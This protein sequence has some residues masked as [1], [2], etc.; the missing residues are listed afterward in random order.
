MH[1]EAALVLV[2]F[3]L[4]I[5]QLASGLRGPGGC[6]SLVRALGPDARSLRPYLQRHLAVPGVAMRED[7]FEC[8]LDELPRW[9]A[10]QL[11]ADLGRIAQLA[12]RATPADGPAQAQMLRL[13]WSAPAQRL[14]GDVARRARD[15]GRALL[16]RATLPEPVVRRYEALF[17]DGRRS[18]EA[19]DVARLLAEHAF[20]C[21]HAPPGDSKLDRLPATSARHA[22]VILSHFARSRSCAGST[23]MPLPDEASAGQLVWQAASLFDHGY[24]KSLGLQE[25]EA[26]DYSR[27]RTLEKERAYNDML[28]FVRESM[29]N[30][31]LSS[32]SLELMLKIGIDVA[33]NCQ[34]PGST[35]SL[36]RGIITELQRR[37]GI[38]P[39]NN[40]VF[41]HLLTSFQRQKN[42][43]KVSI[44]DLINAHDYLVPQ[45]LEDFQKSVLFESPSVRAYLVTELSIYAK[46]AHQIP[47][48]RRVAL[49]GVATALLTI[50]WPPG[51]VLDLLIDSASLLQFGSISRQM[52]RKMIPA[53]LRIHTRPYYEWLSP[54]RKSYLYLTLLRLIEQLDKMDDSILVAIE[55]VVASPCEKLNL[56]SVLFRMLET[57][58]VSSKAFSYIECLI[59]YLLKVPRWFK[60]DWSVIIIPTAP[61][62]PC[63]P[64]TWHSTTG[65]TELSVETTP[66]ITFTETPSSGIEETSTPGKE[67]TTR[68]T[69]AYSTT[70]P[71]ESATTEIETTTE[72]SPGVSTTPS[73]AETTSK[74]TTV[75]PSS[76]ISTYET[77]GTSTTEEEFTT[78]IATSTST[79]YIETTGSTTVTP[80]STETSTTA[81]NTVPTTEMSA[82]TM[83]STSE[84]LTGTPFSETTS[85]IT[86]SE[87]TVTTTTEQTM[88]QT[89]STET[90]RLTT[91]T[92][93]PE[94][95]GSIETTA[96]TEFS[97]LTTTSTE[98]TSTTTELSS[99]IPTMTPSI[100]TTTSGST[101]STSTPAASEWTETTTSTAFTTTE[102]PSASQS[103]LTTFTE[104]TVTTSYEATTSTESSSTTFETPTSTPSLETT[105]STETTL[106][107]TETPAETPSTWATSTAIT[108]E[109][110]TATPSEGTTPEESSTTSTA[111]ETPTGSYSTVMTTSTGSTNAW[112][113]NETPSRSYSTRTTT[114]N[115]TP[116]ETFST[117]TTTSMSTETPSQTYSTATTTS[118]STEIPSESYSTVTT[119]S[120]T[121]TP[122]E[123]YSTMTTTT[124]TS[125]ETPSES[126]STVTTTSTS[127]TTPS[128]IYSTV[129]TTSSRESPSESYS[130]L[131]KTSTSTETPSE[132]YSTVT[133]T[134]RLTETPSESYSTVTTTSTS[135]ETPSESYSTVTT[136]STST[137]TPSESYSTVTTTSTSTE[138][139]SESYSTVTT[140]STSAET[141]S[142]SYPTETTTST[143]STTV[144]IETTSLTASTYGTTTETPAG[145]SSTETTTTSTVVKTSTEIP[146]ETPSVETTTSAESTTTSTSTQTPTG[147]YSLETTTTTG[148]E[149]FTPATETS[150]SVTHPQQTTAPPRPDNR[151]NDTT[152]PT[153]FRSTIVT[154]DNIL[155]MGTTVVTLPTPTPALNVFTV[156]SFPESATVKFNIEKI[157]H[158]ITHTNES[159][160]NILKLIETISNWS[161]PKDIP[162]IIEGAHNI[163]IGHP[164]IE[165]AVDERLIQIIVKA[166]TAEQL[167][168]IT[169]DRTERLVLELYRILKTGVR[170]DLSILR[171]ILTLKMTATLRENIILSL[172][173]R[174]YHGPTE[175]VHRVLEILLPYLAVHHVSTLTTKE[176]IHLLVQYVQTTNRSTIDGDLRHFLIEIL[177]ELTRNPKVPENQKQRLIAI[178]E[179]LLKELPA[180]R[181]KFSAIHKYLQNPKAP[182]PYTLLLSIQPNPRGTA[183]GSPATIQALASVVKESAGNPVVVGNVVSLLLRL[184]STN[185]VPR[186][187]IGPLLTSLNK[188]VHRRDLIAPHLRMIALT[189]SLILYG[190]DGF[191]YLSPTARSTVLTTLVSLLSGRVDDYLVTRLLSF[192][193]PNHKPGRTFETLR[194]DVDSVKPNGPVEG[195]TAVKEILLVLGSIVARNPSSPVNLHDIAAK[196]NS[197]PPEESK[198]PRSIQYIIAS[199]LKK[200]PVQVS[201][202][203]KSA[204]TPLSYVHWPTYEL[205]PD[206]VDNIAKEVE[207]RDYKITHL[208]KELSLDLV[209]PALDPTVRGNLLVVAMRLLTTD[210]MTVTLAQQLLRAIH[211]A[212]TLVPSLWPRNSLL[213]LQDI[214]T[215]ITRPII[216]SLP[217]IQ[218]AILPSLLHHMIN[219]VQHIPKPILDTLIKFAPS[220][221]YAVEIVTDIISALLK[222]SDVHEQANLSNKLVKVLDERAG[223]SAL[224]IKEV[225]DLLTHFRNRLSRLAKGSSELKSVIKYINEVLRRLQSEPLSALRN[226]KKYLRTLPGPA[227][228]ELV[229]NIFEDFPSWTPNDLQTVVSLVRDALTA[230]RSREPEV[231]GSVAAV[232][233][234]LLRLYNYTDGT[235]KRLVDVIDRVPVRDDIIPQPLKLVLVNDI[236]F[237]LATKVTQKSESNVNVQTLLRL[238]DTVLRGGALPTG[239]ASVEGHFIKAV[240]AFVDNKFALRKV[241]RE[242]RVRIADLL[243]RLDL[244]QYIPLEIVVKIDKQLRKEMWTVIRKVHTT[245][246][247]RSITQFLQYLK[248][249]NRDE[250]VRMDEGSMR[251]LPKVMLPLP[252]RALRNVIAGVEDVLKFN[253]EIIHRDLARQLLTIVQTA[254]SSPMFPATLLPRSKSVMD[255]LKRDIRHESARGGLYPPAM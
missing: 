49:L 127:T 30:A 8:L 137:E 78:T 102:T 246:E 206:L 181:T 167:R 18:A 83:P 3:A 187:Q 86:G 169:T 199:L 124:S 195:L 37:G 239:T 129:T 224:P 119:K 67:L 134:S 237:V 19:R 100:E 99:E 214:P 254:I 43:T 220:Q 216:R 106:V 142:E 87:T 126:Y 231:V 175:E 202:I 138:T 242:L 198:Y 164:E 159:T 101:T 248:T 210:Q 29:R 226:L 162:N 25:S 94:V 112:T 20:D 82:T 70:T 103:T 192:K 4:K 176:F 50:S 208:T 80:T 40:R 125:T 45:L 157:S 170:I 229:R 132:S 172:V 165:R 230:A 53:L 247:E 79:G 221:D 143:E 255:A 178:L 148:Q 44:R 17:E 133:T 191:Q 185:N 62:G 158:H 149:T 160:G 24:P 115:E 211:A 131:T 128:E 173:N 141:P 123:S 183:P 113:S 209:S 6:E 60:I 64:R 32:L 89:P 34:P 88:S 166:L 58:T 190:N 219:R 91:T 179:M 196:L 42:C 144:P 63:H 2:L 59:L 197:H 77:T 12:E 104:S 10:A 76:G 238:L 90:T 16:G 71:T 194:R 151:E 48:E 84:T 75:T 108:T 96:A 161:H 41:S 203:P 227:P 74:E 7:L 153:G 139:P 55:T 105:T 97:T 152:T 180:P 27:A 46:M 22:L 26:A 200:T 85:T 245:T 68:K 110:V 201:A 15:A 47:A 163:T 65:T 228:V 251:N 52:A 13:L 222:H 145:T 95:S 23:L 114:S 33:S 182:L 223:T 81:S 73:F 240:A 120:T 147:S 155:S 154:T 61:N 136:T 184:I 243:R 130:T 232:A 177:E 212:V 188:I 14:P 250:I 140:T 111:T 146:T 186:L 56:V 205:P 117:V 98:R 31:S 36:I 189:D 21:R 51:K 9:P 69:T 204:M 5:S 118:T 244:Q 213:L 1:R 193:P 252:P 168:G 28:R 11:G 207:D 38:S 35:V 116:S 234:R 107:T 225:A 249:A 121:E 72:T 39:E 92:E 236:L 253:H 122:S 174:T 150:T 217:P 156:P 54:K 135:T 66:K 235:E 233:M 57:P 215:A 218:T 241:T 171:S 93:T 109:S